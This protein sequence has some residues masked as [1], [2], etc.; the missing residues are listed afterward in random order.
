MNAVLNLGKYLYAAVMAIF[1]LG[2]LGNASAMAP[3]VPIPGGVVWIYV[4]GIALIAAAVSI[5]IG[6]FD[7]LA[8]TLLALMLII[9]ALSVQMQGMMGAADE[10]AKQGFMGN[11]MKDLALAGAALMYA[12]SVAKDNSVIG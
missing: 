5:F 1:G 2:H 6:K 9:F 10:M 12:N 8:A 3:M 7:K 4:T 11:M